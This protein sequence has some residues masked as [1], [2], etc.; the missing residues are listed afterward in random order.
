MI[1]QKYR[2]R[3]STRSCC[4]F[5]QNQKAT[6]KETKLIFQTCE[7]F[8][9][10][11]ISNVNRLFYSCMICKFKTRFITIVSF[12]QAGLKPL[13]KLNLELIYKWKCRHHTW[14]RILFS[15]WCRMKILDKSVEFKVNIT[16]IKSEWCHMWILVSN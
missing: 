8:Q 16:C 2:P 12:F 6:D 9:A 7:G 15:H 4:Q 10:R 1:Q 3:I 14:N 5:V 11:L 13:R